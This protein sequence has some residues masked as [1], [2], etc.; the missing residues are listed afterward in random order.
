[1]EFKNTID[2]YNPLLPPERS[3]PTVETVVPIN[4][5]TRGRISRYQQV[6]VLTNNTD[7][8]QLN[9]KGSILGNN[10]IITQNINCKNNKIIS[11]Y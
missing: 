7:S 4:I 6:G 11:K 10:T 2:P 1:M 8:Y 3:Y 5:P 9:V